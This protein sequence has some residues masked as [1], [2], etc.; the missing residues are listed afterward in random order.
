MTVG[1]SDREFADLVG[2]IADAE[3]FIERH[4]DAL[5]RIVATAGV[6][7]VRLD[8]PL[9]QR[10]AFCFSDYLP[11]TFLKRVGELGIGVELSYYSADDNARNAGIE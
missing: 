3:R 11:P 4:V 9:E 7:D 1:I 5:R 10:D 8:F 6:D 2:Q